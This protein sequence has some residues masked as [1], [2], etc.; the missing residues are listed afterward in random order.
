MNIKI[1]NVLE[2]ACA[3]GGNIVIASTSLKT[4]PDNWQY[5]VNNGLGVLLILTAVWLYHKEKQHE[6]RANLI[7]GAFN[8]LKEVLQREAEQLEKMGETDKV[9]LIVDSLDQLP[10]RLFKWLHEL[11]KS[12]I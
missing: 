9:K 10:S 8:V 11:L 1:S 7:H 4:A 12:S 2:L 6:T 3:V 5:F